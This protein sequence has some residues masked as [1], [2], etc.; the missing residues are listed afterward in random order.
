MLRKALLRF[1]P[2]KNER[3]D[4]QRR[5][6]SRRDKPSAKPR[7]EE[8]MY[9][10]DVRKHLGRT[11]T[12]KVMAYSR[13]VKVCCWKLKNALLEKVHFCGVS[14]VICPSIHDFANPKELCLSQSSLTDWQWS[15]QTKIINNGLNQ[16][17][18]RPSSVLNTRFLLPKII[19]AIHAEKKRDH[20]VR[21]S[22]SKTG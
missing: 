14:F 12:R 11:G 2:S 18:M 19:F 17:T 20:T 7:L 3:E 21:H 15:L 8:T 13:N 9:I 1:L 22:F 16:S 6:S 4:F 5:R 10:P